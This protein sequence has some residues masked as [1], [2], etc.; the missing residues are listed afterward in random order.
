MPP[1]YNPLQAA[2]PS[3]GIIGLDFNTPAIDFTQAQQQQAQL[4]AQQ[5]GNQQN[6]IRTDILKRQNEQ[7]NQLQDA[8]KQQYGSM[9]P[10]DTFDP[11]AALKTAQRIALTQ[12]DLDTALSIEK[13]KNQFTNSGNQL[14]SP[15]QLRNFRDAGIDLPDT[16]TIAEARVAVALKNAG[17][18]AGSLDIRSGKGYRAL[19]ASETNTLNEIDSLGVFVDN[20]KQRY[21]PYISE[22]RGERFLDAAVNPNSAA[23]RMANELDLIA[24][25][26]AAAYNGKRLSDLDFKTMSKLVQIQPLDT[27][28]TVSDKLDRLKEFMAIRKQNLVGSLD[29]A[30][31]NVSKFQDNPDIS[32]ALGRSGAEQQGGLPPL[33]DYSGGRLPRNPD[34]SP[35]SRE[36]FMKLNSKGQ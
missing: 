22:N 7:A 26:M 11:D 1:T 36:Q 2:I 17:T 34:G 18:N 3:S 5:L 25:Q 13:T 4:L 35:L 19:P 28:E 8:L 30:K 14:L 24:T 12:G 29:K 6:E 16:A 31:Y 32:G 9:S 10:T 33:T 15:E 23:A 20:I 27:L 21:M